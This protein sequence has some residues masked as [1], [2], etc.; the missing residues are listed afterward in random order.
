ML[1]ET[2]DGSIY[3]IRG[4][5]ESPTSHQCLFNYF[6]KQQQLHPAWMAVLWPSVPSAHITDDVILLH[7]THL[8][9]IL[10]RGTLLKF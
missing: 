4:V 3:F 2:N 6:T 7:Q 5:K 1:S 9:V 8:I 10:T